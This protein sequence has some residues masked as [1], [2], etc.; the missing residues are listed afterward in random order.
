MESAWGFLVEFNIA[1]Q[2]CQNIDKGSILGY[3]TKRMKKQSIFAILLICTLVSCN[4]PL[5]VKISVFPTATPSATLTPNATAT[6]TPTP[7]PSPT[8]TIP[9]A[10]EVKSAEISLFLGDYEAARRDFQAVMAATSDAD[11]KASAMLGLGRA[12]YA[13]NNAPAATQALQDFLSAYPTDS[14]AAVAYFIIASIQDANKDY[15]HAAE[16]YNQ[17]LKLN[18][19]VID[20]FIQE[21]IG[22][23][24]SNAGIPASA[25][26]AYQA[27]I[28][29]SQDSNNAL[30]LEIKL[31]QTYTIAGDYAKAI[32]AYLDVYTRTDNEYLKSHTNFLL[33]QSY[34]A[35]GQPEQAYSRFQDSVTNYPSYYETYSGLVELVNAGL[36]VDDMQRGLVDYYAGKY[37]LAID[38]FNRYISKVA[39]AGPTVY[40]YRALSHQGL[41]EPGN[42]LTDLDYIL[43]HFTDET[44]LAKA[45][46]EKSTILWAQFQKY[47]DA[48]QL[49][50]DFVKKYPKSP[51]AA[52]FLNDAAQIQE[53]NNALSDAAA[54][55]ERLITEYPAAPISPRAL[56]MAGIT[57]YRNNEFDKALLLFQRYLV[58][59]SAPDEQAAA[60]LWVGKAQKGVGNLDAMRKAWTQAAQIDPTGY[61]SERASE[62][63]NDRQP[64]SL[65]NPTD[66]GYDLAAER[67]Q[68]ET[69]MRTTFH[70]P[71]DAEFSSPGDLASNLHFKRGTAL[72]E[73]GLYDDART[74]FETLRVSLKDKPQ[75]LYRLMNTLLE[76]GIYRSA[77]LASRQIL[78]LASL[79][80]ADTLRA[81]V[82]F[83]HIRFGIYY[84]DQ[85]FASAKTEN[86]NPMFLL[87]VMRQESLFEGFAI[88]SAGARGLMQIMPATGKEISS[89]MKWP[90]DYTDDDLYRPIISVPMGARYLARQ[91][92]YF[93]NSL[94]AALSAYNGGPGNTIQWSQMAGDDPDLLL[95]V[96][97]AEQTRTYIMRIYENFNLYRL[98]YERGG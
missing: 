9:P 86:I 65:H 10:V 1:L 43:E 68:A 73:L 20:D 42:T 56:F 79:S 14:R 12:L 71:A 70:L 29:A 23:A 4:F 88:S 7:R 45:A 54:T 57:R 22:D 55:W 60:Y 41:N 8:P 50:L 66:Y 74:E 37:G 90:T 63:L 39:D 48:A 76:K 62:L 64:F 19:G 38:S 3:K 30:W 75:E 67:P 46:D 2:A 25:T 97:R 18:P 95:E 72:W 15:A 84:K 13:Q 80:D 92:D 32:K 96:I 16:S 21:R 85:I 40:Y 28:A 83:N 49:L 52:T 69:W 93:Q 98:I 24:Y 53:R 31:G 91:R 47:D 44:Y 94:Y 58:L 5:N 81:P 11:L 36:T 35:I 6:L 77:I 33:G 89:G 87:S 17:Y 34:L 26:N 82:Y 51:E 27:A 78:D 61:Y 59:S